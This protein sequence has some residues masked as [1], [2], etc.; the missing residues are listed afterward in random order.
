M[1]RAFPPTGTG[2]TGR[3]FPIVLYHLAIVQL[4]Y[5]VGPLADARVVRDQ[6][7]R[8]PAGDQLVEQL[9]DLLPGLRVQRPGRLVAPAGS[10]GR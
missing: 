8:P 7:D 10:A 3:T 6:D 2:S 4:D 9:E 5:P 1:S